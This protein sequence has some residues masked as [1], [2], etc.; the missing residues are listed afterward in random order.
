MLRGFTKFHCTACGH[1]FTW[2]DCELACTAYTAPIPCPRC[3]SIRTLPKSNLGFLFGIGK[4]R[5]YKSIWSRWEE[6]AREKEAK[7]N[8]EAIE[9]MPHKQPNIG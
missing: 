3:G 9:A 8:N 2:P 6:T 5:F 1:D 7:E 4:K